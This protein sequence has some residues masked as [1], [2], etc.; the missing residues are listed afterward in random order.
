M[1]G[2]I[3][4]DHPDFYPILHSRLPPGWRE[5][6]KTDFSGVFAVRSDS[7]LLQPLS[8]SEAEEYVCGGEYDELDW[9]EDADQDC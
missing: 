9:L 6:L 4:P 7:L 5:N 2:L 1:S 8:K 3:Y